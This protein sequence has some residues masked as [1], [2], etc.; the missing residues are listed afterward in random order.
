MVPPM[1]HPLSTHWEQPNPASMRITE[2]SAMMDLETFEAL[3]DYSCSQPSGVYEGKMWRSAANYSKQ[4][5]TDKWY[6]RWYDV[7]T[8]TNKCS[9]EQREIVIW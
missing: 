7:S 2:E 6:L 9:T 8:D 4:E 5:D 1:T 3:S